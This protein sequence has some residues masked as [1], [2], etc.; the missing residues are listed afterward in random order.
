MVPILT[1]YYDPSGEYEGQVEGGEG[2]VYI[3]QVRRARVEQVVQGR[4]GVE[5]IGS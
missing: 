1:P 2:K 3:G 5:R 4:K